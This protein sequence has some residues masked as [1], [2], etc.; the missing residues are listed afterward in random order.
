MVRAGIALLAALLAV[1]PL[2]AQQPVLV[3]NPNTDE[4]RRIQNTTDPLILARRDAVA[5]ANARVRGVSSRGALGLTADVE[6]FDAR[7]PLDHTLTVLAEQQLEPRAAVA[8]ARATLTAQTAI[9]Q[10]RLDQVE[11]SRGLLI[12]RMILDAVVWARIR[13][14]MA[15]ED[16]VLLRANA[17]LTSRF[18]AGEAKYVDVIR[19]RT[20]RLAIQADAADALATA[21]ASRSRLSALI[22]NAEDRVIAASLASVQQLPTPQFPSLRDVTDKSPAIRL[23]AAE[24]AFARA[25]RAA[26]STETLRRW[27]AG[28]GLQR[29]ESANGYTIGPVLTGS[30]TI[31]VPQRSIRDAREAAAALDTMVV[32]RTFTAVMQGIAAEHRA[33]ALRFDAARA[34]YEGIDARLLNAAREERESAIAA[35]AT[36]E[37]TLVELIDFERAIARAET[38]RLR[39]YLE[40]ID[41][42]TDVW[43]AAAEGQP[44][45]GER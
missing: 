34:R 10:A 19:L 38:Q 9:E 4:L 8:A 25:T 13:T 39:S 23:A 11:L 43:V 15:E 40:M 3:S 31:P 37:M 33:A 26:A 44:D 29:F 14:R 41:A 27:T 42:W 7:R 16:S 45:G 21:Q 5:A 6:E 22:T 24:L 2:R 18:G 35:Y 17:L 28:V 36:G 30:L 1:G 12:D 32:A 20:E